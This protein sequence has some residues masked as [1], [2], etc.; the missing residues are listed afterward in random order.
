[1]AESSF[2]WENAYIEDEKILSYLLYLEHPVGASKA[3]FFLSVGYTRPEWTRLRDDL[4]AIARDGTVTAWVE[5]NFGV[6]TVIDGSA[7]APNGTEI[8]IRT[9]W[10]NNRLDEVERLV[11]AYPN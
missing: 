4:L 3:Q 1:M 9:V 2:G 8:S 6:K 11:T 5:S 10:I 7:T